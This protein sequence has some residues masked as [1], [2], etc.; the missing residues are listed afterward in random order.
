MSNKSLMR[1][2]PPSELFF[3]FVPTRKSPAVWIRK[4]P[5]A[6]KKRLFQ[7]LSPL[8]YVSLPSWRFNS[9]EAL[10]TYKFF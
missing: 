2:R 1:A 3:F 5:M 6:S 7:I 10:L 9:I 8:L 4:N